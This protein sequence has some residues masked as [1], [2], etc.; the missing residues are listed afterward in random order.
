MSKLNL[1][2]EDKKIL[3]VVTRSAAKGVGYDGKRYLREED[4]IT[5]AESGLSMGRDTK[6]V[7][8][9][10]IDVEIGL[11]ACAIGALY[12]IF[13]NYDEIKEGVGK[14]K[15]KISDIFKKDID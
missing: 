13:M 5:I 6:L 11:Y 10:K 7:E 2:I 12:V 9:S 14:I 3:G 8:N 15:D 1:E 4:A